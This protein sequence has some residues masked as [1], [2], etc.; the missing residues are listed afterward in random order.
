MFI[1]HGKYIKSTYDLIQRLYMSK[2]DGIRMRSYET[3]LLRIEELSILYL[4][5]NQKNTQMEIF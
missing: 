3:I 2:I 1:M 5:I 4:I